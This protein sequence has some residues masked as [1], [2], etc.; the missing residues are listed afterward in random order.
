MQALLQ[1]LLNACRPT[2]GEGTIG[3]GNLP[4]NSSSFGD[5]CVP[6]PAVQPMSKVSSHDCQQAD[7]YLVGVSEVIRRAIVEGF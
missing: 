3:C 7:I 5:P 2:H 4:A 1:S 6:C